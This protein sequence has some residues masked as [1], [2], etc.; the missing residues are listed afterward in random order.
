MYGR[1][2]LYVLYSKFHL[3]FPSRGLQVV[4]NVVN[5]QVVVSTDVYLNPT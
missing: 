3:I 1:V 2:S 4:V 5:R